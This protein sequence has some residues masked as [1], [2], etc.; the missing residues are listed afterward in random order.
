MY[1]CVVWCVC[2]CV[3]GGGGRGGRGA[4]IIWLI[5]VARVANSSITVIIYRQ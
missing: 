3:G 4:L 1:V 2:V 5:G